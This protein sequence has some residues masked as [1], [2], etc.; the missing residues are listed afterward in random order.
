MRTQLLTAGQPLEEHVGN[1]LADRQDL[2]II[3][4]LKHTSAGVKPRTEL[5]T[6]N[7]LMLA[8]AKI[9]PTKGYVCENQFILEQRNSTSEISLNPNVEALVLAGKQH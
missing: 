1:L 4:G 6:Y 5:Q 7:F 3:T 9:K 2:G 8:K